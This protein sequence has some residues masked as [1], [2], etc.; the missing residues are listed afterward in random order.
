AVPE[1]GAGA[2]AVAWLMMV[3][4]YVVLGL[5]LIALARGLGIGQV[6]MGWPMVAGLCFAGLA[7]IA[8]FFVPAGI[9]VREA[10]LAWYLGPIIGPAPAALLAVAARIWISI[11]EAALIG[12]GLLALRGRNDDGAGAGKP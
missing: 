1:G 7:G 10:A 9:G 11:G 5:G 8:A 4:G 2:M 6:G 3:S 12:G